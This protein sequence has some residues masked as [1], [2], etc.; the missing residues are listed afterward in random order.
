MLLDECGGDGEDDHDRD[1]DSRAHIAKE[2]KRGSRY[3]R[4]LWADAPIL[5]SPSQFNGAKIAINSVNGGGKLPVYDCVF[6]S[7]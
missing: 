4:S 6:V 5:L 2:V 3:C 1:D 7:T